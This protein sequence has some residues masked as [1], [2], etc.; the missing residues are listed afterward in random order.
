MTRKKHVS[1]DKPPKA[2]ETIIE[3]EVKSDGAVADIR[4]QP[5]KESSSSDDDITKSAHVVSK[6]ANADRGNV[7]HE[8]P[9]EDIKD[10]AKGHINEH[11]TEHVIEATNEFSNGYTNGNSNGNENGDSKGPIDEHRKIKR[12]IYTNKEVTDG[13]II[14]RSNEHTNGQTSGYNKRS[15]D[16][17]PNSH[18]EQHTNPIT[19]KPRGHIAFPEPREPPSKHDTAEL[20]ELD[21]EAVKAY[22]STRLA[23]YKAL[24]GGVRFVDVI[25]KSPSGKILKRILRIEAQAEETAVGV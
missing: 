15:N 6:A 14:G 19:K 20:K 8:V 23:R 5:T 9:I 4:T 11:T 16:E 17:P 24:D 3:G 21:E 12:N 2:H 7:R 22:L 18:S 13:S 10:D 25:P 1:K